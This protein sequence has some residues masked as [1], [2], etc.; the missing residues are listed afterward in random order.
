MTQSHNLR[1]NRCASAHGPAADNLDKFRDRIRQTAQYSVK[2]AYA[3]GPIMLAL[4]R[5]IFDIP[6]EE[7]LQSRTSDVVAWT[8]TML[9]VIRYSISEAP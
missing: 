7:R 1:N 6:L 2:M 5:R 8:K 3:H 9:A 4:D